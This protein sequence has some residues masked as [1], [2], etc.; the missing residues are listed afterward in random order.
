[1]ICA[2]R[3]VRLMKRIFINNMKI[4]KNMADKKFKLNSTG[5]KTNLEQLKNN[6]NFEKTYNQIWIKN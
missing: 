6:K 2:N 1:M 3:G 5:K 4:F